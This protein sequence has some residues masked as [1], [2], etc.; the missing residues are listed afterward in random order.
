MAVDF[1]YFPTLAIPGGT[2]GQVLTKSSSA[3]DNGA[4]WADPQAG[5]GP[6]G[7]AGPAG[8]TGPAGAAGTPGATGP[9]GATGAAGTNGT[10]G[11]TGAT[12]ATG[13]AGPGLKSFRGTAVTDGSGNVTFN[14]T[15]AGFPASPVVSIGLQPSTSNNITHRITALT[16]TSCTVQVL[17]TIA[18]TGLS[19][20]TVHL[21]AFPAGVQS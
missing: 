14:L 11:A 12:G 8:P 15:T 1:R 19:G 5:T 20:V 21:Q 17:V 16:S 7:P 4:Q 18:G 2:A 9:T 3:V 10:N 13:P 6:I